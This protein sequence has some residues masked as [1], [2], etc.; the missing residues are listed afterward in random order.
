MAL[1]AS[2]GGGVLASVIVII[3][4]QGGLSL[5]ASVVAEPLDEVS[6]SL[7]TVVGGIILLATALM[8]LDIKKIPVANM[9]PGVFLPPAFIWITEKIVPGL[10]LPLA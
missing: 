2:L 3:V 8:I 6:T 5:L 7:M 9:L 10:L 4:Y 1:A